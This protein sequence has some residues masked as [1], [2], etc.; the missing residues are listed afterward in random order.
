MIEFNVGYTLQVSQLCQWAFS[1]N[2]QFLVI[3]K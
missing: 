3:I 1:S 2:K